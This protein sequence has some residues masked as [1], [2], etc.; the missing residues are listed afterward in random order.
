MNIWGIDCSSKN[1]AI[2]S[3]KYEDL[4][5]TIC[6]TCDIKDTQLRI[7]ELCKIFERIINKNLPDKVFIEESIF[8][9]NFKTSKAITEV[10]G[11][12]KWIC[13]GRKVPFETVQNRVWKKKV[14][15]NGGCSKEDIAEFVKK[16]FPKVKDEPQDVFDCVGVGLWGIK[17]V[18]EEKSD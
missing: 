12:I 18:E 7:L 2:S 9:Q 11:N 5:W 13:N 10:I 17:K 8:V 4:D 16:K 14:I 15:G 6:L 3:F 1:I